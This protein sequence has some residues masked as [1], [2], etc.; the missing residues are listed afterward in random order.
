MHALNLGQLSIIFRN[1]ICSR[2]N[3]CQRKLPRQWAFPTSSGEL[4]LN[5]DRCYAYNDRCQGKSGLSYHSASS[6]VTYPPQRT[7]LLSHQLLWW[8]ISLLV[9]NTNAK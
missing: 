7:L 3:I 5:N 9:N 6:P 1:L 4:F 2:R 8:T